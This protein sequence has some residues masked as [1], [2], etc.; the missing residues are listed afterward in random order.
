M[1]T[2]IF[3]LFNNSDRAVAKVGHKN[4]ELNKYFLTYNE[5]MSLSQKKRHRY[6]KVIARAL[7]PLDSEKKSKLKKVSF[8]T[9]FIN[10]AYAETQYRCVGGGVPVVGDASTNCGVSSYA[11]FSCSGGQEICN[12]IVFGV[13]SD[14]SPYCFSNATTELCFNRVRVRSDSFDHPIFQSEEFQRDYASFTASIGEICDEGSANIIEGRS[15]VRQACGHIE[16]QTNYNRRS[17]NVGPQTPNFF[18]SG[19]DAAAVQ[20]GPNAPDAPPEPTGPLSPEEE[21]PLSP[22]ATDELATDC[23]S[24]S[25]TSRVPQASSGQRR[26]GSQLAGRYENGNGNTRHCQVLQD[27]S[28]GQIAPHLTNLV[29]VQMG[30][31]TICVMPDY[32]SVGTDADNVRMPLGRDQAVEIAREMGFVL[33]TTTM[34]DRICEQARGGSNSYGITSSPFPWSIESERMGRILRHDERID[35]SLAETSY[36]PGDLVACHKKD[37]VM[38]AQRSRG[39]HSSQVNIYG[40]PR[41]RGGRNWQPLYDGHG[42]SYA[43]YSHGVRL[44][45]QTAFVNGRPVPLTDL[46]RDGRISSGAGVGASEIAN[47][48]PETPSSQHGASSCFEGSTLVDRSPRPPANP[49]YNGGG[50]SI[51]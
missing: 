23:S 51:Q 40:W 38:N 18:T 22:Q 1:L 33:P 8:L 32:L 9:F 14:G 37:L 47:F 48:L 21:E 46:I 4:K 45:S 15:S 3:T 26:N 30:E 16:R 5:L 39:S 29:P 42:D 2:L 28:R 36:S 24:P 34:V 31:V 25:L 11:G 13:Q 27:M 41:S 44:V 20:G 10:E 6:L 35:A 50:T 17:V 12:P 19:A 7:I 43:D 49:S